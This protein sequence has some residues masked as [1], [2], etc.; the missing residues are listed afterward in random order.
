LD[1]LAVNDER[2]LAIELMARVCAF[3]EAVLASSVETTSITRAGDGP[4]GNFECS[5]WGRF[6]QFELRSA[7]PSVQVYVASLD[8]QGDEQLLCEVLSNDANA[9]P[10]LRTLIAAIEL[11]GEM[12]QQ[13]NTAGLLALRKML[14]EILIGAHAP[15]RRRWRW[16]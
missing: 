1:G 14:D 15:Q 9:L 7:G 8:Q 12:R 5:I 6:Y 2:H 10:T 16:I 11:L 13:K 4:F 3:C